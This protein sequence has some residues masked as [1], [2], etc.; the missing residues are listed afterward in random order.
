MSDA[1][2]RMNADE[3]IEWAMTRPEGEHYELCGGEVVG[4]APERSGMRG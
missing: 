3:F 1:V 2:R 4:M